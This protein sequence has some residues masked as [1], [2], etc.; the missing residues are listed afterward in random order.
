MKNKIDELLDKTQVLADKAEAFLEE[1]YDK[2]KASETYAKITGSIE[3]A[4][5]YVEKKIEEYKAS[6]L[7][8][9]IENIRDKAESHTENLIDQAKA[10]GSIIASD[11]DEAIDRMKEKLSGDGK[12]KV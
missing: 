9:K 11:V 10:Y 4:G 5:A 12:K 6:D 7:P 3:Q 8:G 1:N 2:A